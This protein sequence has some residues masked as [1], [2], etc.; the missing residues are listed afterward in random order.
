MQISRRRATVLLAS[1]AAVTALTV[2]ALAGKSRVTASTKPVKSST[3][4]PTPT[5]TATAT[6]TAT[7]TAT[8]TTAPTDV[9]TATSA[10]TTT[11]TAAPTATAS[12]VAVP[13]SP[14]ALPT[15]HLTI[16]VRDRLL[17]TGQFTWLPT[18]GIPFDS[19]YQYVSGTGPGTPG[20]YHV[21]TM[22]A[23]AKRAKLD[24][25]VPVLSYFRMDGN[26]WGPN[27]TKAACTGSCTLGDTP[28]RVLD[29]L[30]DANFMKYYFAGLVD[31]LTQLNAQYT[32]QMVLHVEPDLSGYAQMLSNDRTRCGTDCLSNV[33]VD[34]P[35]GVRAAVAS[36]GQPELGS[37]PDTLQGFYLA[38]LH[39][40]DLYAPRISLAYHVSNWATANVF[41][42]SGTNNPTN[43][44]SRGHVA[45][46]TDALAA[47]VARF[48]AADGATTSASATFPGEPTSRY[49][50][51]FNDVMDH[52]AAYPEVVNGNPDYWWDTENI[53]LPN[54][55]RWESYIGGIT[56]R[57]GL[58]ATLWQIPI[59]NQVFKVENNTKG[60]YQDNKVQYLFSHL[61]ELPRVGVTGLIFGAGTVDS[62]WSLDDMLDVTDNSTVVCS[63]RGN[64][65][66]RTICPTRDAVLA[67]DDGGYLREQA[68]A[69]FA[70][71]LRLPA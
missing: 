23:F 18:I 47:R 11:A 51:L 65:S 63:T 55:S 17:T 19:V 38:V 45:V 70:S 31:A 28:K 68:A 57:T 41:R 7:A 71:P 1:F 16:G 27:S 12:S 26:T 8:P 4:S 49:D 15:D 22:V 13:T 40:R 24:G 14:R 60:H 2:P 42:K 50:L 46:D 35:S 59:G 43:D 61:A 69:Y 62:T 64:H 20:D 52:D 48:A 5:A 6:P 53:D 36:S 25:R 29:H 34:D 39:L 67:D 37:Y 3:T 30:G 32:G 21:S 58:K 33:P 66:G 10:A 44:I 9:A 54:Y 56:S